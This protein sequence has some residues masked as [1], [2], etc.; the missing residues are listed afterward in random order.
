M[1]TYPNPWNFENNDAKL[2][3]SNNL[4][5]VVYGELNEIGMGAPIGAKCFIEVNKEKI[6][7][8]DWCGGPP[9]W[10][11]SGE[12]LA[13]PI[14]NKRFWKGTIQQIGIAN[15]K[16]KELK[17]YSKT[18]AVL[19]LRTF[20]NTIVYGYDS[21]IHKTKTL[22]FDIEKEKIQTVLKF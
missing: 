6:K 14:W 21:P 20:D 15:L 5:K 11:T 7:I 3:S 2:V 17:I 10:E 18:F 19:D 13:I 4:Y 8:H 22:I 1:E 16:T 12:L 9:V